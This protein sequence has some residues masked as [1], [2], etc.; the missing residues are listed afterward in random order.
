VSVKSTRY[1]RVLGGRRGCWICGS[2]REA[3]GK[4]QISKFGFEM[5]GLWNRGV[6]AMWTFVKRR[7]FV[8][9]DKKGGL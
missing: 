6:V 8:E 1:E 3:D 4:R 2:Q 5:I 9:M 7:L